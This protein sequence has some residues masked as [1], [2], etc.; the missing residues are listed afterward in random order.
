[1]TRNRSMQ[2][3]HA[4]GSND[5]A[6]LRTQAEKVGRDVQELASTAGDVAMKR[7]DPIAEY[8]QAEPIKSLL[9]AAAAGALLAMLFGRR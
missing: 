9:I 1:M 3:S 8:V 2:E 5:Y 4:G 7:L 6:H